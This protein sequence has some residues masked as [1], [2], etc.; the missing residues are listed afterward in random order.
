MVETNVEHRVTIQ[1]PEV[2]HEAVSWS[3]EFMN[4]CLLQELRRAIIEATGLNPRY[5]VQRVEVK[6]ERLA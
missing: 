6:Q 3:T 1:G 4:L 5:E 2:D